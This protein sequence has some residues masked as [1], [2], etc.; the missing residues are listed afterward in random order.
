M[1]SYIKVIDYHLYV[2][3]NN[4]QTVYDQPFTKYM[5]QYM[6]DYLLTLQAREKVT[7]QVFKFKN[8]V[9]IYVHEDLMLLCVQSYRLQQA[10]YIN[11]FQIQ[12]WARDKKSVIIV[13]KDKYCIR[14]SSYHSFIQQVKK[15]GIMIEHL[16]KIDVLR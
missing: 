13:F 5:N 10:F 9:P 6:K 3:E 15:A 8:K 7:K 14:L 1:L 11:Y 2:V 16:Q 4:N 12:S